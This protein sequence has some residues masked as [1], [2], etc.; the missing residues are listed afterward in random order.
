MVQDRH[1]S[2]PR[3]S[4][5][6]EEM[7]PARTMADG[8]AAGVYLREKA[9][10]TSCLRDCAGM[11]MHLFVSSFPACAWLNGVAHELHLAVNQ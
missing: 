8:T 3:A 11:H 10:A 4:G 6:V 1:L 7:R 2:P 9:N 5:R